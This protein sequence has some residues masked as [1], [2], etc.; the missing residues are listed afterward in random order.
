MKGEPENSEASAMVTRNRSSQN[1][2]PQHQQD[3]TRSSHL[4]IVNGAEKSSYKCTHC[5]QTGHTK[6]QCFEL[7]GYS[8]WW[9]HSCDPRKWNS[10][11]TSTAA[12]V[13]TQIENDVARRVSTLVAVASNG[14]KVLNM[15]TPIS[16]SRW[17]IG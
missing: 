11:K 4:K 8:E 3:Q 15:S 10:K 13:E 14:V 2:P 12:V 5:D 17:I 16:N 6:N 9:N 1:W 7:V